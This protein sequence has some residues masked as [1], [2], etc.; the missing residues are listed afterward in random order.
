[1][2]LAKTA[3]TISFV[4]L[5]LWRDFQEWK[6]CS[7]IFCI[8]EQAWNVIITPLYARVKTDNLEV[9]LEKQTQL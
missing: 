8:N 1:M 3:G 6:Q 7:V 9:I 5:W 4:L 2:G